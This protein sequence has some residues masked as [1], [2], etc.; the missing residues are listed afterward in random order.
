MP[1]P[2]PKKDEKE[3]EFISR[4]MLFHDK[5]GK[6]DLSDEKQK[7]QAIAICYSQLRESNSNKEFKT[8]SQILKEKV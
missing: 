2:K 8:L 6:F 1:L 4:C 3:R 5:D 7:K